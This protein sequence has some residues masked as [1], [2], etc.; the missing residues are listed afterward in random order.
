MDVRVEGVEIAEGLHVKNESGLTPRFHG[1]E[2]DPQQAG[3]QPAKLTEMAAAVAKERPYQLRQCEHVLAMRYRG[4]Q[5]PLQPLTVGEH[6]LLMAARAEVTGPAGV[7]QQVIVAAPIAV[8]ARK[9]TMEV[10]AGYESF[11]HLALDGSVDEPG[12]VKFRAVSANTLIQR[13]RARIAR[14]VDA[15]SRWLRVRAHG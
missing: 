9:A 4:E 12:R 14:L 5:V 13:T 2:A 3:N 11:E 7:G 10:T 6:P 1:F 8:D 15:A